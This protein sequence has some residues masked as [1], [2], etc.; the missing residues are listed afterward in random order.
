VFLRSWLEKL[1]R[2]WRIACPPH[3]NLLL[4][5]WSLTSPTCFTPIPFRSKTSAGE[6]FSVLWPLLPAPKC[7]QW[8]LRDEQESRLVFVLKKITVVSS[9]STEF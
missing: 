6:G 4:A 5:V 3:F 2:C 8:Y 7:S 1:R 9:C